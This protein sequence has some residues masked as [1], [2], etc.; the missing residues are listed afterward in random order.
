MER[1]FDDNFQCGTAQS[2]VRS[3]WQCCPAPSGSGIHRRVDTIPQF[4]PRLE[5]RHILAVQGD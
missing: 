1:P 5:V 4:L 3:T 2:R